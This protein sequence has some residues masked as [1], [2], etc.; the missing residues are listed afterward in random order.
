MKTHLGHYEIIA[1]LGRGGMGVVYKGYEPSLARFVAIKE[2]SATLANEPAVVERFLREARS[3]AM[4]NDP[5][6]IQIYSIGQEDELPFF[7]MEFVDGLSVAD[8]VLRDRHLQAGDAMKI[9][10]QTAQGLS[11][12]HDHGVIHRDIKPANLMISQRGQIKIAD[13]G[14]ALANHDMNAKLTSVGE[15][16]GTPGYLPPEILLGNPVDQRSDL[17]ALGVVL[18]EMLTGRTPFT[19]ASVYK[20]MLSVVQ[21]EVPDVRDINADIDPG[22]AAILAKML[23]KLPANR[24]QSMHEL[25]ADLEKHPLV[26]RGGSIGVKLVP[27]KHSPETQL[28]LATP[29]TPGPRSRTPPASA[30]QRPTPSV[31]VSESNRPS[32]THVGA[33]QAGL[34]SAPAAPTKRSRKGWWI[35]AAAALLLLAVLGWQFREPLSVLAG[36]NQQV[37]N[38]ANTDLAAAD[39][40]VRSTKQ[41]GPSYGT[42]IARSL[43]SENELARGFHQFRDPLVSK[44]RS[45]LRITGIPLPAELLFNVLLGITLLLLVRGSFRWLRRCLRRRPPPGRAAP[46]RDGG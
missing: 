34:S 18:F 10:H 30:R 21:E 14:I 1:E 4:L 39:A 45:F 8:L 24:Y 12:A 28:S 31:P 16:V 35:G 22:V 33:S 15:M 20:L 32:A 41:G 5:H 29:M 37:E 44:L 19:D 23:M 13:F 46:M 38:A 6:I 3:M 43:P 2:L 40:D 27:E 9:V 7:V 11:A 25:I 26:S 42:R 36:A 17:Y